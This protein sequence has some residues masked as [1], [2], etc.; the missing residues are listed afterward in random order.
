MKKHTHHNEKIQYNIGIIIPVVMTLSLFAVMLFLI[1]IPLQRKTLLDQKRK[2]ARQLTETAVSIIAQHNSFVQSGKMSL[3]EAQ[4]RA[5]EHIRQIRYGPL[6]KDYFWINDMQPVMIMHPYR[7]DL[8]GTNIGNFKDPKGKRLFAE[9]VKKVKQYGAGY[10]DYIWQWKDDPEN[11]VPK[12]S[13]VQGFAPWG[14]IIGTGIYIED[15]SVEIESITKRVLLYCIVIFAIIIALSIFVIRNTSRLERE[16]FLAWK[17]LVESDERSKTILKASPNPIVVYDNKGRA[18]FVNWAFTDVFGWTEKEVLGEKIKFVPEENLQEAM[19]AIDRVYTGEE[20]KFESKRYTKKGEIIDVYISASAF[21]DAVGIATGMVVSLMD[22]TEKKKKEEE[23]QKRVV[24]QKMLADIS[25]SVFKT[26]DLKEFI[27]KNL[28]V[29]GTASGVSVVSFFEYKK[30]TGAFTISSEWIEEDGA[31]ERQRLQVGNPEDIPEWMKSMQNNEIVVAGF[32]DEVPGNGEKALMRKSNIQSLLAI[33]LFTREDLFGFICLAEVRKNRQWKNEDVTVFK[34]ASQIITRFINA[35]SLQEELERSKRMESLGILAG[36][37]AH[38]LNN[39]L[40]AIISYPELILMKLPEDSPLIKPI[41]SIKG[42]G[43]RA[44]G[45]VDDLLTIARGVASQKVTVNLNQVIDQYLS[46]MEHKSLRRINPEVDVSFTPGEDLLNVKGSLV[47]IRKA[48]MNIVMNAFEATG[49]KGAIKFSTRNI[50]LKEPLKRYMDVTEGKYA[51]IS[52]SDTGYGISSDDMEMIFEPFYTKK[53]MGRSGTGLGLSIVWSAM[54][55][56]NG[57]VDVKAGENG[58]TFELYFFATDEKTAALGDQIPIDSISGNKEKILVV[59]DDATQRDIAL[60]ILER[61]GYSVL[62]VSSGEEAV[63]HLK[64][65]SADLVVLD[66][67][68]EPGISGRET[69]QKILE[70][71]PDQKAIVVS[72]YSETSDMK[73]ILAMGA[74]RFIKKPYTITD[75][76]KAVWEELR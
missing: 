47:H 73:Q 17:K 31:A 56:H 62:A 12:I 24:Y 55:D 66:M 22:I 21:K 4:Y 32:P 7:S 67:I 36:S 1:V 13:Y 63:A 46:S 11:L 45:V 41:K 3:E 29:M 34:T 19:S 71:N 9:M 59:D 15:V 25:S 5:A 39:I 52:I 61:L 33:P 75:L 50:Y 2:T 26:D 6:M 10:V 76:G 64:N 38:D 16:R 18:M 57:Y 42:A 65:N 44:A 35:K 58:T 48:L 54:Q 51:V 69:Y 27:A 43:E 37:V 49:G 14:W 8:E 72:G 40:S 53:V 30:K 28:E 70:D 23:L 68:M 74:G 60:E 20:E